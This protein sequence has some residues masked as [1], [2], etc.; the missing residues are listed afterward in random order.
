MI[1]ENDHVSG[2]VF[3]ET[4]RLPITVQPLTDHSRDLIR[5]INA[6]ADITLAVAVTEGTLTIEAAMATRIAWV[7]AVRKLD[8]QLAE[9]MKCPALDILAARRLQDAQRN[10]PGLR[11][12]YFAAANHFGEARVDISITIVKLLVLVSQVQLALRHPSN[13]G[14]AAKTAH[15]LVKDLIGILGFYD[16][17]FAKVLERGNNPAFDVPFEKGG[18]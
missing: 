9:E 11:E 15:A 2:P 3:W 8:A 12:A 14:A 18:G 10:E 7:D 5:F 4:P 17:I 13:A 6:D 16:P 1:E